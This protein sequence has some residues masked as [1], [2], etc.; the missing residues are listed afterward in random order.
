MKVI[1]VEAKSNKYD[2][3]IEDGLLK[4]IGDEIRKIYNGRKIAIVTDSN[5]YGIYGSTVK[6]SLEKSNFETSFIVLDPGEK[7]KS[8]ESLQIVY[9]NFV[10]FALTRS[11]LVIALG[12][13]VI[14]D[15]T[16][17]AAATYL[18]GIAFVQVPTT[19]LAQI[20]SSIGGKVA[21]NLSQGKNLIGSFYQPKKVIIDP[22]LLNTL[23]DEQ[24]KNGLSEVVKYACIKDVEFFNYLMKIK[25]KRDLFN[26]LEYIIYTC[27]N[28]KKEIVE[29]DEKDNNERM[30]LNFGHTLAHAL[31]KYFDYNISHGEAVAIGMHYI[32]RKT[33]ELGYTEQGTRCK[34]EELLENFHI[35]YNLPNVDMGKIREY[36]LLDK[37]N[38]SGNLN[39][40]ILRKIGEAFIES[41]PIER[42]N[43]FF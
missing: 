43:Y 17:F 16:G 20:D 13:G 11:D 26:A 10:D 19:L 7:S 9:N 1:K 6:K 37:K 32:T 41:V 22:A 31:E 39:F 23:P 35:S 21:V 5:V 12:G 2:I 40:V 33:E 4:N 28:I 34:L 38:L 42:I 30:L 15:I 3:A 24:I 14:G 25:N 8:L 29:I 27:C 18:R 36:V